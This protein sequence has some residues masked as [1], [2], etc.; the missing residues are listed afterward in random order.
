MVIDV[1]DVFPELDDVLIFINLLE[2]IQKMVGNM[3]NIFDLRFIY[4]IIIRPLLPAIQGAQIYTISRCPQFAFNL[5]H[6]G[7]LFL[8]N[9]ALST[10]IMPYISIAM[11]ASATTAS[12]PH[13]AT[14]AGSAG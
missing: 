4:V 2:S 1:F 5:A 13:S 10:Y 11:P 14:P 8:E 9:V 6:A 12:F 7:P 3:T